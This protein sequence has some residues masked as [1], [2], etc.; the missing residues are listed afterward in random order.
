MIQKVKLSAAQLFNNPT[1]RLMLIL[2]TLLIAALAG[3]A[4]NEYTGG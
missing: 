2:G 4:P 3:G 1:A